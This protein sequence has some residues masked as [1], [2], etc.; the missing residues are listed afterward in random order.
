MGKILKLRN[1][2][3]V[4]VFASMSFASLL[5]FS[6]ERINP[7]SYLHCDLSFLIVSGSNNRRLRPPFDQKRYEINIT[8]NGIDL[9]TIAINCFR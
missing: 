6:N 4:D 1:C 2:N 7:D 3:G 5:F 8:C 9:L